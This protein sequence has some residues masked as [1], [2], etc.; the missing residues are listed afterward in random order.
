MLRARYA[1]SVA[2]IT[3]AAL[4]RRCSSRP[5]GYAVSDVGFL[6]A[7]GKVGR[8]ALRISPACILDRLWS[9]ECRGRENQSQT[10][11]RKGLHGGCLLEILE[12]WHGLAKQVLRLLSCPQ[13][14]QCL[15]AP[16]DR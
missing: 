3:S 10:N 2:V 4:G 6:F 16:L 13:F 14:P 11:Y 15:V 8:D 9:S 1:V 5:V 12:A 7:F